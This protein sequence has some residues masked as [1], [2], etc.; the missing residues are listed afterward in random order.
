MSRTL[1]GILPGVLLLLVASGLLSAAGPGGSPLGGGSIAQGNDS[2]REVAARDPQLQARQQLLLKRREEER[3]K[4]IMMHAMGDL[5][6]GGARVPPAAG[7][8]K[9]PVFHNPPPKEVKG[10]VLAVE[11]T[12]PRVVR[13]S[14]GSDAGLRKHHTLEIYRL[15]PRAQYLGR[16]LIIEV[17]DRSAVGRLVREP[18]ERMPVL[19]GGDE[20]ASRLE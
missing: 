10:R 12:D 4:F 17:T 19:R 3:V 16:L 5:G 18:G 9:K 11:P 20:V 1:I 8:R 2:A 14:L 15:K 13:V 6:N 7:E